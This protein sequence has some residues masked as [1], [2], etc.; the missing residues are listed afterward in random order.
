VL[1]GV[2]TEITQVVGIHPAIMANTSVR[3]VWTD[4]SMTP[5]GLVAGSMVRQTIRY[6]EG[7]QTL[8]SPDGTGLGEIIDNE[9]FLN[10]DVK[11]DDCAFPSSPGNFAPPT[12]TLS[13][14]FEARF[15]RQT[16]T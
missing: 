9:T 6:E 13:S 5:D 7:P 11:S 12:P 4:V 1:D 14:D 16:S 15:V 2:P 3:K 10:D 8:F